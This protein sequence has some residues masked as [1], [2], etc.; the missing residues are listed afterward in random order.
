MFTRGAIDRL[1]HVRAILGV[2][3]REKC[4]EAAAE[5]S[6][7]E[8]VHRLARLAPVRDAGEEVDL[9]DAD[10]RCIE[11]EAHPL[12]RLVPRLLGRVAL[13]QP[14]FERARH[15]VDGVAERADA[16]DAAVEV[17]PR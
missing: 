14:A 5:G 8:A 1:A 6:R 12:F 10:M 2:N 9:P 17:R 11:S 16:R 15:R 3:A 7:R 4:P 13:V